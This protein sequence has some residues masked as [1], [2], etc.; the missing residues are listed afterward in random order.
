MYVQLEQYLSGRTDKWMNERM[1]RQTN[2]WD[3]WK[4]NAF[5]DYVGGAGKK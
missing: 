3:S 2:K 4:H 1:N 5:A